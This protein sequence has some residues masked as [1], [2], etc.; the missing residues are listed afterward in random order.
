MLVM[1]AC[2]PQAQPLAGPDPTAVAASVEAY[3]A[4][5]P[6]QPV[7]EAA[8]TE[9]AATDEP[10]TIE[11]API[12]P[13]LPA[14]LY[15]LSEQTGSWQIW[16]I[17]MNGG[18]AHPVTDL[19]APVYG[20]DI[21]A[22]DGRLAYVSG[23]DLYVAFADG[24]N[25]QMVINGEDVDPSQG[26]NPTKTVGSPR[27]S[28]DGRELAFSLNGANVVTLESG[29]VRTLITNQVSEEDKFLNWRSYYPV[30]W[31]PDGNF[32]ATQ[33]GLYEGT[34]L[35]I[36]PADGGEPIDSELFFCCD[37][38]PSE[39]AG[40][41]YLA[42]ANYGYG[43]P[44]LW[45]VE[46]ATGNVT[47]L[48]EEQPDHSSV[49]VYSNPILF[50]NALYSLQGIGRSAFIARST[51]ADVENF[52]ILV[53]TNYF[54][55]DALWS[56]DAS[57]LVVSGNR[58]DLPMQIWWTSGEQ[59]ILEVSGSS[60]KWGVPTEADIAFAATPAP[61]PTPIVIPTLPANAQPV[62]IS[63]VNQLQVLAE[64]DKDEDVYGV[65]ISPDGKLLALGLTNRVRIY[66]LD[67]MTRA[68]ELKSYRDIIPALEFS[69]DSR[70]L[71]V[72]SWDKSLDLWEMGSF[73]QVK[74]FEGHTDW[75][76]ALAFSP[77]GRFIAS[78][79]NDNSMIVWNVETGA[80]DRKVSSN[81]WF[82]DVDYSPDG[83][84]MATSSWNQDALLLEASTGQ[85]LARIQRPAE[86]WVLN[87]TFSPDG[88]TLVLGTWNYDV[89]LYDIAARRER[90]VLRG[91]GDNPTGMAF[92]SDGQVLV[93]ADEGG[94]LRFWDLSNG[95]F[96][97]EVRGTR[98]LDI[99]TDG[100]L[101][102]AGGERI[103]GVV[104][105][106]VP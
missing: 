44:G 10:K 42:S 79:S 56:P 9:P 69:P 7:V 104:L 96:L 12:N 98:I 93:T 88:Q 43:D 83:A 4:E 86:Q 85:E 45:K 90:A 2:Q 92:T 102:V 26:H 47:R 28:P 100:R 58:P 81:S 24:S 105:Y 39:E 66:D 78:G 18:F 62:T 19:P 50:E 6:V 32:I 52:E 37:I 17:E 99:S 5:T 106:Y 22:V 91:H 25:A 3:F 94:Q 84:T 101:L 74:S 30:Y 71:A 103:E 36:L 67:T 57:L 41:F 95:A 60:L 64:M 87:L 16:R 1:A 33:I 53:E 35:T 23:N 75:V 77:D 15:F 51:P 21:S 80:I 55:M 59:R 13:L 54:P 20:F 11:V 97:H 31:S 40:A 27:W 76:A 34:A 14:P 68:A 70:Y 49:T 65:A 82:S 63:N 29:A 46:W 8:P 89:V 38:A 61:S 72:G 73:Q 48:S